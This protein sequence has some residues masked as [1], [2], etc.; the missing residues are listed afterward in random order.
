MRAR[1]NSSALLFVGLQAESWEFRV[2]FRSLLL[3]E[4]NDLQKDYEHFPCR[5]IQTVFLIPA[6]H[7]AI[8]KISA[9][10]GQMASVLGD[11][12]TFM[13][14]LNARTQEDS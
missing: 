4:G 3:L 14:E 2:L 6:A 11:V 1:L 8:S 13:A 12:A 7:A 9:K 10:E 5:L